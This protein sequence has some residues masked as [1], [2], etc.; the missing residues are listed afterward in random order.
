MIHLTIHITLSQLPG[1]YIFEPNG[2]FCGLDPAEVMEAARAVMP[3][4]E[5]LSSVEIAQLPGSDRQMIINPW[6]E[7]DQPLN[8]LGTQFLGR[9]VYGTAVVMPSS[10]SWSE[11]TRSCSG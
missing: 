1:A 9:P 11:R 6:A 8:P 2:G 7:R 3:G 10:G 4:C 5:D